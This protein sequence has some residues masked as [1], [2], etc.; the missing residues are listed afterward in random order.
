M[1]EAN[2]T[3][4]AKLHSKKRC[5]SSSMLPHREQASCIEGIFL[6]T[7]LAVPKA[8]L[9]SLQ[10]KV[11]TRGCIDL[12][13]HTLWRICSTCTGIQAGGLFAASS[14]ASTLYALLEEHMPLDAGFQHKMSG[15]SPG[16]RGICKRTSKVCCPK[17]VVILQASHSFV[18]VI[19]KS[20]ILSEI[21]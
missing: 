21:W 1:D 4:L 18:F 14:V 7:L 6:C 15:P 19:H 2:Q 8:S 11:L 10:A 5:F 9:S 16:M 20:E 13:G 12:S 3:A 17:R